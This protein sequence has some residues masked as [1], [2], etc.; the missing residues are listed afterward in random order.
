MTYRNPAALC[1]HCFRGDCPHCG[2]EAKLIDYL[3]QTITLLAYTTGLYIGRSMKYK[4][5]EPSDEKQ[6]AANMKLCNNARDF[7]D[8]IPLPKVS[9]NIEETV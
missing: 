3:S 9:G 7:I 8:S 2:M 6:H 5:L 1:K 4:A